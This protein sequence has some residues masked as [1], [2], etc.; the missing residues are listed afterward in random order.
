MQLL[1]Q[2]CQTKNAL[3]EHIK[4]FHIQIVSKC[5]SEDECKFGPKFFWF[6]PKEDIEISY[7]KTTS[8]KLQNRNIQLYLFYLI[9]ANFCFCI[10][11]YYYQCKSVLNLNH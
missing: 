2:K 9:R 7:K 1:E 8:Q 11:V 10:V 3:R 4:K 6:I 5:K